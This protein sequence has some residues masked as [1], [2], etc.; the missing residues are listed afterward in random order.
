MGQGQKMEK[1]LKALKNVFL[2]GMTSIMFTKMY[3]VT[4]EL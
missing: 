1:D 2:G 3:W 4:C